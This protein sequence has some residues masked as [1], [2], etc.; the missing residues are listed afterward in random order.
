MPQKIQGEA[1]APSCALFP[2]RV[3]CASIM[4]VIWGF[5]WGLAG[6]LQVGETGVSK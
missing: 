3:I 1:F 4:L 2:F 5:I 6:L